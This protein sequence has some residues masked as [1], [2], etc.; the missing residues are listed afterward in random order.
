M[1]PTATAQKPRLRGVSHLVAA[2]LAVPA[3]ALLVWSSK[4]EKSAVVAAI[5]GATL[6]T[7]YVISALYHVPHWAERA[8]LLLRRLDHSAIFLLIAGTATPLSLLLE[9][10]RAA[11]LMW[12]V[13]GG[14]ALGLVRALVWPRAPKWVAAGLYV[15]LGWAGAPAVFQLGPTL[16]DRILVLLLVGGVLYSLGGVIYALRRPNPI[17]RVFGYH[18]VF[19]LLVIAASVAHFAAVVEMMHRFEAVL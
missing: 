11:T 14:A 8:R 3:S 12:T 2:C 6:T 15:V 4:G 5:Y 18:E 1:S 10:S 9:P 13:W 7:M 17:P 19:H 16:G